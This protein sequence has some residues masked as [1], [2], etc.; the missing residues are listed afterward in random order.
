MF[1]KERLVTGDVGTHSREKSWDG[2]AEEMW[3]LQKLG[4]HWMPERWVEDEEAEDGGREIEAAPGTGAGHQMLLLEGLEEEVEGGDAAEQ[5]GGEEVRGD[6][7][8]EESCAARRCAPRRRGRGQR[9]GARVGVAGG[10]CR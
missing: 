5:G 9:L 6:S 2:M 4:P 10:G 1:M 3:T 7:T 8:E